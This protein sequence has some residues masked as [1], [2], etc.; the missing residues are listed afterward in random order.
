[1]RKYY[2]GRS[3]PIP[4]KLRRGVEAFFDPAFLSSIRIC[5]LDNGHVPDPAF[6]PLLR[7]IGFRDLPSFRGVAAVTFQDVI[8][9]QEDFTP[10]L[11]FHELV[12][13]VQYRQLGLSRFSRLYVSGFISGGGYDGIP[14]EQQANALDARFARDP[15]RMFQV[16]DEVQSWISHGKY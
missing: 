14:L 4:I 8:V 16:E 5:V 10:R 15:H 11:L 6:Y 1:M 3:Y 7:V 13:A 12:H 9:G 2:S